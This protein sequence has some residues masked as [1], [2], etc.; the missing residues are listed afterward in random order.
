MLGLTPDRRVADSAPELPLV[1]YGAG[2]HGKVVL[3]AAIEAGW[4]VDC[5]VDDAPPGEELLGIRILNTA[6]LDWQ[7][8]ASCSFIVGVGTNVTRARLFGRLVR[9]G[10]KAATI[11]HPGSVLSRRC[12]LGQGVFVAAGAVIGVGSAVGDDVILN[13]S[14]SVDHDCRIG[15]HVHICPGVHLAG[16]VRVGDYSMVGTGASV[17]P[18]VCVGAHCVIGAGAVVNRDIPDCSVAVGVPA[19][20][21][22]HVQAA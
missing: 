10:M 16:E 13:T 4:V 1:I 19:R 8:K 9:L 17:L 6:T 21:I 20:V 5:L 3:D 2:G 18:G 15:D 7:A 12:I 11:C 22:K 14:A